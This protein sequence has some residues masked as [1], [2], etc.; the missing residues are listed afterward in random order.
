MRISWVFG[1][2]LAA[3]I[4][5]ACAPGASARI[6]VPPVL[7]P[8]STEHHPGKFVFATLVT[9]DMAAA[10]NFYGSLFGWRFQD[11]AGGRFPYAQAMLNGVAVGAIVQK[12][13][14]PGPPRQ[15]AWIHYIA[16][17]NADAA[18]SAATGAGGQILAPP[19][20]LPDRGREAILAD[21][22]GSV[23]GVLASSSGD[24]PDVLK[25]QG[26][27]IWHS[28]ITND[29]SAS[30]DFYKTV[31]GAQIETLPQTPGEMHMLLVTEGYARASVNSLPVRRPDIH[32]HWL[33]FV[34]VPDA[35]QAVAQ[36]EKLGGHVLVAPQMDRHGGQLAVVSDPAGAPFGV[37]EW[38]D[39]DTKKVGP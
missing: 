29:P 14:P 7:S 38:S 39:T 25:P 12:P 19:H 30:A 9:P 35:G 34:R 22:Q 10:K 24:A 20:D 26:A 31:L 18:A 5:G 28:E 3:A 15:P 21:P 1:A 27:W 36:V 13:M 4:T 2:A 16:V 8:P 6:T 33:G 23:F 32:P 37:F 11:V 17:P